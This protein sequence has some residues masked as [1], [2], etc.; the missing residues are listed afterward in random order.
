MKG[1]IF[2]T[3]L[4]ASVII[5][6]QVKEVN[7]DWKSLKNSEGK[8]KLNEV[9]LWGGNINSKYE[10]FKYP[11]DICGDSKGNYYIADS[12]G[13]EIVVFDANGK[14]VKKIGR[15]GAGPG[16]L[17][18]PVAIDIDAKD[19]LVVSEEGNGR[20]Q[21]FNKGKSIVTMNPSNSEIVFVRF[22]KNGRIALKN[23]SIENGSP[24]LNL[25]DFKKNNAGRIGSFENSK[26]EKGMAA[27]FSKIF[28]YSIDNEGNYYLGYLQGKKVIEKY[29]SNGKLLMKINYELSMRPGE[30]KEIK[31][32]RGLV[33]TKDNNPKPTAI[34]VDGEGNIYLL[35]R[36]RALESEDNK[37]TPGIISS[38]TD[39]RV[40]DIH[41]VQPKERKEK[42]NLFALIVIDKNG[43]PVG[44]KSLDYM[45]S[46][47][48][49]IK[50]D[51]FIT[52]TYIK[53][54]VHQYKLSK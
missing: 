18:Y 36:S 11:Q 25:Y 1:K 38:T 32:D 27:H 48:R 54:A 4:L 35:I 43:V 41:V 23:N 53:S 7:I 46:R 17:N 34:D 33:V 30:T 40:T 49:V 51:I 3:L 28:G 10:S 31:M 13:N 45:A 24:L 52:D 26:K 21:I 29:N 2:F 9:K 47:V 5:T 42:Y 50:G 6:A 20:I 8:I 22:D 37:Y 14:F 44:M 16:D 15:K 39:S 19:N 12:G